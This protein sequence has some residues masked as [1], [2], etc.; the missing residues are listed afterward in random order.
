M[1]P[2]LRNVAALAALTLLAGAALAWFA[3]V[4]EDE[5]AS[6]RAEAELRIFRELVGVETGAGDDAP[7]RA[8]QHDRFGALGDADLVLCDRG[9]VVLRGAGDGYAGS[10][11][12]AVALNLDGSIKG[13]R[14][15]KHAETPGFGDI[16]NTPSEWLDSFSGGDVHAV[17]GATI[18]SEAVMAAVSRTMNRAR[19]DTMCP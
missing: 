1:R 11:R 8:G 2:L 6:N 14:V 12:L 7:W 15:P 13:V 18:T 17:T 3:Q 4:T 5:V 10:F 9:L 19:L 16:L